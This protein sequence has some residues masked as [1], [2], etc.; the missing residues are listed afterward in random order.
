MFLIMYI[1]VVTAEIEEVHEIEMNVDASVNS[2]VI[3]ELFDGVLEES[4][5]QSDEEDEDAL[6]IS[7]MSLLAPLAETV[8]AVVKSPE[9]KPMV[10]PEDKLLVKQ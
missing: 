8:A 5:D 1:F 2:E 6:N 3:N 4:E 7:S 9:R 10:R